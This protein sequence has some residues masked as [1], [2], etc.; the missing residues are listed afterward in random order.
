MANSPLEALAALA[1]SLGAS[2]NEAD[3]ERALPIVTRTLKNALRT[4]PLPDLGE[5]EPAIGLRY[6]VGDL[7]G[8]AED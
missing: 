4:D 3:L 5:T 6:D 8:G 7:R 2:A 1:E